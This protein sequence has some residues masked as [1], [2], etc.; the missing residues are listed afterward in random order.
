VT[1][2]VWARRAESA[3]SEREADNDVASAI[4]RH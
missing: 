4:G 2:R 1:S 3:M